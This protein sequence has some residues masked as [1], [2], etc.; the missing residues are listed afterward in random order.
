MRRGSSKV[1]MSRKRP[2]PSPAADVV[3]PA[4]SRPKPD[5]VVLDVGGTTFTTSKNTLVANSTYFKSIFREGWPDD[6]Y[7]LDRDPK[8]FELLLTYMRSGVVELPEH[9][10]SL[11][12][13]VLLEAQFL[14]VDGFLS[15]VKA[16]A[17]RNLVKELEGLDADAATNFDKKHGGSRTHSGRACCRRASTGAC[18]RRR[19]RRSASS[20]RS[21]W[22]PTM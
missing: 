4:T 8:T 18:R 20:F 5:R 17:Y 11:A 21:C 14:G 2:A 7:F 6:D 9:D 1:A 16:Q 22:P 10:E 13:R 3:T 19:R 12:R 15:A